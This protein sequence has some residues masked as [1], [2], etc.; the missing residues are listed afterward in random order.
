MPAAG[1]VTLYPGSTPYSLLLSTKFRK[2]PFPPVRFLHLCLAPLPT[3]T[4]D[5]RSYGTGHAAKGLEWPVVF[6]PA[7][8]DGAPSFLIAIVLL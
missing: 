7:C 6:L 3:A 1:F 5:S 4:L 8:E 2:S